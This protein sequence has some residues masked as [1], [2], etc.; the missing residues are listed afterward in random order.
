MLCDFNPGAIKARKRQT[1]RPVFKTGSDKY[2]QTRITFHYKT[3]RKAPTFACVCSNR[4]SIESSK[5][6]A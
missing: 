3:F 6:M 2:R 5:G 1:A 4:N